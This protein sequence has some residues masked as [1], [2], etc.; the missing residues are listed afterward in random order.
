MPGSLLVLLGLPFLAADACDLPTGRDANPCSE[1]V[2]HCF[3]LEID[4]QR[5]ARLD[6]AALRAKLREATGYDVCWTL[7]A[8]TAGAIDV[9]ML[10]NAHTGRLGEARAPLDL[11]VFPLEGQQIPTRKGVRTD[12]TVRIGGVAMQTVVDVVDTANLPAGAYVVKVRYIGLQHYDQ[13]S[14]FVTVE[15]GATVP[16]AASE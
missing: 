6:D 15:R 3:D 16:P 10:P 9:K 7:P 11:I 8:P 5:T 1:R 13:Q 14:V 12:P 4:G 2:G